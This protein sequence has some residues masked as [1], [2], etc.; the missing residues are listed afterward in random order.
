M[1]EL[2]TTT[3]RAE[4]RPARPTTAAET[5]PKTERG[6]I[7][8][9]NL[10]KCFPVRGGV[11][12]KEKRRVNVLNGVDFTIGEGE[13]FGL[14]G[15]SGCGKSTLAR[16]IMKLL[17]PSSGEIVFSGR[18]LSTFHGREKKEFYRQVQMIFQDP[19]SSLN[20]RLQVRHIIGEM[21]RIRGKSKEEAER[22]VRK[23]LDDVGLNEEALK[24]Y[25]H[26]FSGGQRQRIAIARALIVR[27][28]LLIADEPVSALDLSIQA[29]ILALLRDLKLKYNLTI[30][31][32]SHDLNTVSTFCDRLAVM[33]LGRIVEVLPARKL[34]ENGKHP[35]L[36]ALL[37]S[38][39]IPDPAL[40]HARKRIITGEVPSPTESSEGC[41]FHPRCRQM[42]ALCR[43]VRPLLEKAEDPDHEVACHCV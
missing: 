7:S 24:R 3:A 26:E 36:K 19:Y 35:Y 32:I 23:I 38:I 40:R 18:P 27:P 5:A 21:L 2:E 28:K 33:Y 37:D 16:L 43:T 41:S 11:F 4:G 12:K 42:I 1:A 10:S 9:R 34:F 13:I 29:Q 39:P 6:I 30:L 31:F 25:P 22:E 15:E 8:L 20:P 14:V 17:D